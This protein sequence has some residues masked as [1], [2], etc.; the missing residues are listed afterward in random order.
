[1]ES[2]CKNR[3][4]ETNDAREFKR[5]FYINNEILSIK[6]PNQKK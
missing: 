5:M 6:M 2:I 3:W 1:M 4:K